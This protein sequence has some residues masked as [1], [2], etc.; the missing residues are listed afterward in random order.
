MS[1][2]EPV[3]TMVRS[4]VQNATMLVA[5]VFLAVGVLGFVP[6]IT[7]NLD[8]INFAGSDSE[9]KLLGLFQVNVLHNFV[10]VLFGVVGFAAARSMVG[11]RNFLI[12]GGVVYLVLWLYG[13]LIDFDSVANFVSLNT[14]DNWLHFGLGTGMLVLGLVLPRTGERLRAT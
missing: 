2:R 3:K 12:W 1:R 14:A 8:S 6:G 5:L 4:P 10:H 13:M 9:A 7:Q 11:A